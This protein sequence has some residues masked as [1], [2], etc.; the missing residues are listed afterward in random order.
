MRAQ[1]LFAGPQRTLAAADLLAIVLF[2][3]IGGLS[4]DRG[5]TLH[6]LRDALPVGAGWFAAAAAFGAYRRPGWRTLLPT[7]A[8]GVTAGVLVRAGI[9]GRELDGSQ[10]AFL[11]TTLVATLLLVLALRLVWRLAARARPAART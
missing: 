8:A 7:W 4:H 11:A 5:L 2:A 6:V 9:L 3:V 1:A 10:A